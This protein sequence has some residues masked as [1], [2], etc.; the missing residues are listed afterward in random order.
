MYNLERMTL[1]DMAHASARLRKLGQGASSMADASQRVAHFLFDEFGVPEKQERG[2]VLARVYKTHPFGEL[3]ADL[4]T[5]AQGAS[6]LPLASEVPCL[7]LLG[8]VGMESAWSARERSHG[9]RAIPL[10]SVEAVSR[11]PMVAQLVSQLGLD[12]ASLVA[13]AADTL[14]EH[15]ERTF[16]VFHVP[17]APGSP[18]I[19]AQDFVER[20]QV[21]SVLGFGGVLPDGQM[22]AVIMFAR[23]PVSRETAETFKPLA[24]SAKL[25][26]LPYLSKTFDEEPRAPRFA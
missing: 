21:R 5:F 26:L 25:A 20:Y 18:Y 23:V 17:E 11:L 22:Y 7:V 10:P 19:P 14:L 2:C 16:N 8:T 15:N 6:P 24:L 4:R 3:P 12:V 13:S 9:H 1:A